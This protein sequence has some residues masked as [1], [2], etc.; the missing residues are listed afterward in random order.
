M[1]NY[2]TPAV[3]DLPAIK[4]LLGKNEL[5]YLDIDPYLEDFII[6]KDNGAIVGTIGVEIVFPYGLVR[7]LSVEDNYRKQGIAA[8]LLEKIIYHS[9]GR[10]VKE[11]YLLTT[12]A[13]RFFTRHGFSITD[14]TS[15]PPQVQKT[16]EFLHLCPDTAVCMHKII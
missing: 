11:L 15:V 3:N 2:S 10:R 9:K 4:A 14:R 16:K 6:A 7:S 5:P 13:D 8:R 1:I 12:T